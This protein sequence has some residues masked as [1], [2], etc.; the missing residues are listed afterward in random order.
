MGFLNA[1]MAMCYLEG[2][3]GIQI[4]LTGYENEWGGLTVISR[5]L[6]M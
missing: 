1:E 4:W 5:V 6:K 2:Y 3:N